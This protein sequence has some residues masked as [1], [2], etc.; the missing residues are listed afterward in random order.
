MPTN[1]PTKKGQHTSIHEVWK[2]V[3]GGALEVVVGTR[4]RVIGYK[5]SRTCSKSKGGDGEGG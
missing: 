2:W 3:E 1:L 4:T 5:V